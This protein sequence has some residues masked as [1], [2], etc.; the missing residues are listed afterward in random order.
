MGDTK[1]H[2]PKSRGHTIDKEDLCV[3]REVRL[4]PRQ[5]NARNAKNM[6]KCGKYDRMVDSVNS[7]RQVEIAEKSD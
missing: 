3:I 7:S 6:T 1:V 5:S 2:S 4:K